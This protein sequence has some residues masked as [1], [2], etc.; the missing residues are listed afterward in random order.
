MRLNEIPP[1]P[2]RRTEPGTPPPQPVV[3]LEYAPREARPTTGS[4]VLG[5]LRR[6]TLAAGVALMVGALLVGLFPRA[7]EEAITFCFGLAL[8]LLAIP[9]PKLPGW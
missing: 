4:R 9:L 7:E 5:L 3:P 6:L 2:S 1:P 8:F